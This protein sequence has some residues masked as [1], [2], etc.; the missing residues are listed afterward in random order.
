MELPQKHFQCFVI[1]LRGQG[2]SSRTPGRYILDNMGNDLVRFN[3]W[4]VGM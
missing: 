4:P 3:D 1:D 2:R